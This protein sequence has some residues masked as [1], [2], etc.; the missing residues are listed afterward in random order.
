M[1][2]FCFKYHLSHLFL[3]VKGVVSLTHYGLPS[4]Y[5]DCTLY[6]TCSRKFSFFSKWLCLSL[7][8]AARPILCVQKIILTYK[9]EY[10]KP[11]SFHAISRTLN[12]LSAI[13]ALCTLLKALKDCEERLLRCT[14]LCYMTLDGS[15]KNFSIGRSRL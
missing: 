13:Q 12:S 4:S 2:L 11:A 9:T 15:L 7:E 14:S 5:L 8:V 1:C 3:P 10:S 6:V